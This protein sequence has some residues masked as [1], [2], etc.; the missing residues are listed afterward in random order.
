MY[1]ACK[2]NIHLN[3]SSAT[4][5]LFVRRHIIVC[6]AVHQS[7]LFD[8]SFMQFDVDFN[9]FLELT[10]ASG[11]RKPCILETFKAV[12]QQP[13]Y[14]FF[15]NKYKLLPSTSSP[16]VE[17]HLLGKFLQNNC[18]LLIYYRLIFILCYK[19]CLMPFFVKV[20]T[21]PPP[22]NVIVPL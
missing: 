9:F 22:R 11:K 17:N 19:I 15:Q 16:S 18:F 1:I 12:Q 4:S 2:K 3:S 21:S 8:L 10:K 14:I 13:F 5:R 7:S 6:C 20:F